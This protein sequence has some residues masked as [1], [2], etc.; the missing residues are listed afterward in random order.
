MS[1]CLC[2]VFSL[3][4]FVMPAY[5]LPALAILGGLVLLVGGGELLVR[6]AS[7]L[8]V[9]VGISPLV[10]GLTVVAFGTSSPELAV[11]LQSAFAGKADIAVGN[12]VG[13]NIFNVLFILGLS[14]VVSPLVISSQL[15]RFDVPLMIVASVVLWLIALDGQ[16]SRIDG[17]LLFAALIIYTGW[18]VY[19]SRRE[20]AQVE[21]EFETEFGPAK[22]TSSTRSGWSIAGQ[23]GLMLVGLAL[24]GFGAHLLVGGAAQIARLLGMSE[25]LIGLTIVAAGTSLPEAA[26]SV[27][28]SV[29]GQRDIA[30]GNVVGS[31]LFNILCV[32][33]LSATVSP[34]GIA[35]SSGALWFD[36]P[37]MIAAA[38]VC[39]PIFFTGHLIARWE[40]AVL[41]GYFIAYITYLI[42][43][44]THSAFTKSFSVLMLG[45]VVPLTLLTI[46]VTVYQA[47]K[48]R[49]SGT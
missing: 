32:L 24:L 10:I 35:I 25:L 47:W 29:R 27:M 42:L 12:V 1:Q 36:I 2:G 26:A 39:L 18:S 14:A 23:V 48:R 40:G 33:G 22:S 21:A 28:A 41:L 7:R 8:A 43:A 46:G 45:F 31:N 16:V 37:V 19:Q 44:A 6:G 15:I 20:N 34:E 4:A 5:L 38:V 11:S 9:A 49:A 3:L 30:V 13:S 17:V